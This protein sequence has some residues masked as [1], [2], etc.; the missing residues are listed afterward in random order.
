MFVARK[1][2]LVGKLRTNIMNRGSKSLG[3][4][5]IIKQDTA[6]HNSSIDTDRVF[7]I[8]QYI[9]SVLVLVSTQLL[10]RADSACVRYEKLKR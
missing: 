4:G 7:S 6:L 9:D 10:D 5:G 2:E 8:E 3:V 1:C